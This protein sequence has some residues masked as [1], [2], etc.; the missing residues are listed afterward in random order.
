MGIAHRLT[1]V[2]IGV[3]LGLI[4]GKLLW[5][6]QFEIQGFQSIHCVIVPFQYLIVL[7]DL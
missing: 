6:Y 3:H 1:L 5:V 7:S 4:I 2:L